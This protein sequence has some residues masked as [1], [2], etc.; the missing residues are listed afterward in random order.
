MLNIKYLRPIPLMWKTKYLILIFG[1]VIQFMLENILPSSVKSCNQTT[2]EKDEVNL[3]NS[4]LESGMT[5]PIIEEIM[6]RGILFIII[7]TASNYLFKRNNKNFDVLGI[8]VFFVFSSVFF[9]YV[10]V[11]KCSDIE[12]IGGYL[13]SGIAFTLVFL[14]TRDIKIPIILHMLTNIT[15]VLNRNDY[16]VITEVIDI[17]MIIIFLIIFSRVALVRK[18]K[19]RK[20]IKNQLYYISH[21][22]NKYEYKRRVKKERKVRRK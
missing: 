17:T 19:T 12:N 7:L 14:M 15:S 11:A 4:L 22:L 6:F 2:I 20:D 16:K 8:G 1:L 10:H 13:A 3:Y 9:G 21:S 5:A 18:S